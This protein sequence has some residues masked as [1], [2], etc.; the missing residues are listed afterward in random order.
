MTPLQLVALK[1]F[2]D[3]NGALVVIAEDPVPFPV[4]RVFTVHAD[5][6]VRRGDHA[7]RSCSQFLVAVSGR[8]RVV[9]YDGRVRTSH[10]LE[11]SEMGLL[12]PP[13]VWASQTSEVDG[14]VLLVLCDEAF[15]EGDYIRDLVDF[16]ALLD[17]S[18]ETSTH[19]TI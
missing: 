15:D 8:I 5:N 16:E 12:I 18:K 9:T 3:P 17:H 13:M 10:V 14:S 19:P 7:H 11:R 4:A 2:R 1:T 6:G